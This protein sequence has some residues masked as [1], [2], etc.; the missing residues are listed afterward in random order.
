M[1]KAQKELKEMK[2]ELKRLNAF[3]KKNDPGS[4]ELKLKLR[5][6]PEYGDKGYVLVEPQFDNVDFCAMFRKGPKRL[7][8]GANGKGKPRWQKDLQAYRVLKSAL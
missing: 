4:A 7:K 6:D 3:I 1:T 8:W 2:A 5:D